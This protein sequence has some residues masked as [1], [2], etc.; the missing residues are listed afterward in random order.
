[1][2]ELPT[3]EGARAALE[4]TSRRAAQVR[5]SDLQL[6]WI[7]LL[8][9]AVYL[10][11]GVVVSLGPRNTPPASIGVVGMVF[12][13]VVA[14][15]AIF[16]RIRAY[17]RSGIRWYFATVVAFNFWNTAVEGAS[18]G[19]R[20]W[21]LGQPTYHFGIS[22]AIGVIPLLIGAWIIERRR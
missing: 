3:E 18:I 12:V 6:V 4:E 9:A 13:A 15:V 11:A 2:T 16:L 20:F 10:A 17:S 21:A 5:S 19:T 7:L 1:M 8:L 14:T 22:V